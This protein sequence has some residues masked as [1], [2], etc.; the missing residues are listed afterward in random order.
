M[1]TIIELHDRALDA[2]TKI[3][4]NVTRVQFGLPTPCA[5]YDVLALLNHMVGGNYRFVKIATGEPGDL[6]LATG[7]F[8]EDE[9]TEPYRVS[10]VAVSEAWR[11]PAIL[12]RQVALPFGEFPGSFALGIHTVEAIVHGWDLAK[13]TGQPTEVEPELFEVAWEQCKMVDENFRGP[14]R[15]FGPAVSPP[16]S[17]S[18]TERLVAWLG[19]QP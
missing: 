16:Q 4:A 7:A 6:V 9:A 15:P 12:D 10:A 3:V 18:D 5:E 14:G 19:R 2:T 1:R 8:V 13:A 11:D 17:A